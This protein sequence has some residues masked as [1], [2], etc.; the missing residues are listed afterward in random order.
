[1]AGNCNVKMW[2]KLKMF[3]ESMK[4]TGKEKFGGEICSKGKIVYQQ[5]KTE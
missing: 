4:I 1:M 2:L 3:L 5:K